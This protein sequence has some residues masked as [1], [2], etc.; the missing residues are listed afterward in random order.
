MAA[1]RA[2]FPAAASVQQRPSALHTRSQPF[3]LNKKSS[4]AAYGGFTGGDGEG[5]HW[6]DPSET[7]LSTCD[8]VLARLIYGYKKT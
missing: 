4:S 2:P 8:S 5:Q 1:N 7:D 6:G 3:I